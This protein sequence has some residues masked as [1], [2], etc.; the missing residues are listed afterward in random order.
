MTVITTMAFREVPVREKAAAVA[1]ELSPTEIIRLIDRCCDGIAEQKVIVTHIKP[2]MHCK[3]FSLVSCVVCNS[4][5]G[6]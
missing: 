5:E 6:H 2:E 4:I 3:W 1:V